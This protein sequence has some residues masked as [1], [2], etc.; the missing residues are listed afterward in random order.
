MSDQY[1]GEIRMFGGNF[2]PSGWQL[3]NGQLLPI[4]QYTALFSI[5]GVTYG[6]NGTTN[7]ALPN[8]QGRIPIHQGTGLNL[9]PYV[10]GEQ[11]GVESVVLLPNQ[12]PMHTHLVS[13][14]ATATAASPSA[15]MP[16]SFPGRTPTDIYAATSDGTK[17]NPNMLSLAGGNLPVPLIQ[18]ILCVTFIIAMT[19]IYPSRN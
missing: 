10:L 13:A 2:A 12:M 1:L 8:M 4:N 15:A 6:G 16:A 17:M 19:G 9:T 7:F 18:P 5:L 3:C 14:S 11:T